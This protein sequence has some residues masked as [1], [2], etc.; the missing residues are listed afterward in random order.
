M[1]VG[2]FT[3]RIDLEYPTITRNGYGSQSVTWTKKAT[4]WGRVFYNVAGQDIDGER[5]MTRATL[6]IRI[7]YRIDVL[8]DWRIKWN[9]TYYNLRGVDNTDRR[10]RFTK[11]IAT[12]DRQF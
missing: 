9:G 3:E 12:I 2:E 1:G 6:E 7:H 4:V 10:R 5:I 11:L 8:P